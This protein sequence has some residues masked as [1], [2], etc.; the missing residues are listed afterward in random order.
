MANVARVSTRRG[1]LLLSAAVALALL[2]TVNHPAQARTPRTMLAGTTSV[3]A[4]SPSASAQVDLTR[5]VPFSGNC[6]PERAAT[7]T[8]TA[9]AVVVALI[10]NT[11]PGNPVYF[12]RFPQREGGHTFSSLC[13]AGTLKAGAY[14]LVMVRTAG[15]ATL[16]LRL[17]G[18]AG[19]RT[20]MAAPT[21]S[22][23]TLALLA[24]VSPYN[25]TGSVASFGASGK[26]NSK[27]LVYVLGWMRSGVSAMATLGDCE[28][29]G[30]LAELAPMML[31][32]APGCPVGGSGFSVP[33]PRGSGTSFHGGGLGNVQAGAY[34]AGLYYASQAPADSAG[35]MAVWI[36]T[37]S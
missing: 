29:D 24:P 25:S 10:P 21:R 23:A 2:S 3:T 34:S 27:G 20:V 32:Q 6:Y 12:G 19:R 5:D 30:P 13:G 16:T 31:A 35:G 11:D 1:P 7:V 14:T 9:A 17:P 26:L 4:N 15:T 36:P 22:G 18:L 37:S 8:G 28:V 33:G